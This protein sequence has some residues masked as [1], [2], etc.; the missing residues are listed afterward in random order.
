[1]TTPD[2]IS[3]AELD[4]LSDEDFCALF[5]GGAA[6]IGLIVALGQAAL[7]SVQESA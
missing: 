4:A 2:S 7:E 1:M 5:S 3:T 6:F